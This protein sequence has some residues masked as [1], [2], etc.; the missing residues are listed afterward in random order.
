MDKALRK[1]LEE[2]YPYLKEMTLVDYRV[3]VLPGTSG[4]EAK[5]RV[6]IESKDKECVWRTVGVSHDI[7]EASLNALMDSII[8]KL[9]RDEFKKE[10]C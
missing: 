2:F 8:Y 7:L 10:E 1:A 3:R 9:F 4:T 5:I 6:L